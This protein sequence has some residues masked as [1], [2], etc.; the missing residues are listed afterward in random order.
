VEEDE[1]DTNLAFGST[2]G[3]LG[4]PLIGVESASTDYKV[5]DIRVAVVTNMGTDLEVPGL[6]D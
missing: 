4:V 1:E 5:V 6:F 2:L 3:A